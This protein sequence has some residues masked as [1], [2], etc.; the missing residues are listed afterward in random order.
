MRVL[1][2]R[3]RMMRA[4]TSK[5]WNMK[6]QLK[7]YSIWEFGQRKDSQGNPHQEDSLFPE[8][9]KQSD[10][11]RLFI[12]CDGMGGHDAGE[13]ASA[14]VCETMS[15]SI[16][17]DGYDKDGVFTIDDFNVAIDKAFIALDERDSGAEKKMGT[18]M[19][20]L[21]FH[22]EGAFI[23]HMGDS[24]VYHIRPGRDGEETQILFE[25]SDHSLVNDLIKVGE[26]TKEEARHSKQKNVITRAMQPNMGRRPKAD[27]YQTKDIKPGDYFYMCSDGMLEQSEMEDGTSLKNVFSELGGNDENKV[28]I[29]KSVTEKNRDNHTA[30]IIHITDVIEPI[31]KIIPTASCTEEKVDKFAAIVEED[32]ASSDSSVVDN[33]PFD[34]HESNT[35]IES[36]DS[37]VSI[38]P[39]RNVSSV[40][41][42]EN[43]VSALQDMKK[44]KGG[45]VPRFHSPEVKKIW[46]MVIRFLVAAIVVAAVLVGITSVKS[47]SSEKDN[48]LEEVFENKPEKVKQVNQR[49]G[50]T[51]R[52]KKSENSS[53]TTENTAVQ[54]A[55]SS[56]TDNLTSGTENSQQS[57]SSQS[58][59]TL[60]PQ[61]PNSEDVVSSDAQVIQDNIKK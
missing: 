57:G 61:L 10:K 53:N 18:T 3:F 45:V 33:T 13:V 24:R 21:K 4:Q 9:G 27:I 2:L 26:L 22:N 52:Q 7:V 5:D 49:R 50:K 44:R 34:S 55:N 43:N 56:V 6:Y 47:C 23:A 46:P 14:T 19:T 37:S 12:L 8:F 42:K 41:N 30:F 25:T 29:L 38:E 35:S 32:H 17:N 54:A 51:T 20:F 58:S 40:D 36:I 11:D 59:T 15:Q 60:A 31:E 48:M 39:E 28:E 16:L 1:N